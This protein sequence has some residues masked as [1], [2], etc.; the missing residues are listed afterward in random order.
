MSRALTTLLAVASTVL[1]AAH[2]ARWREEAL[3]VLLEVRGA[4]RWRYTMDTIVKVPVLAWHHRRRPSPGEPPRWVAAVSGAGL[5]G[6]P[7]LILGAFG[8]GSLISE[9]TAEF[10]LI[11]APAGMLP[12]VAA[13]SL[14]SAAS[15]GGGLL[16]YT[17]AV[18]LAVFAGT[19][20]VAA[21][22]L[23]VATEL[24]VIAIAGSVVPGAW[25]TTVCVTALLRR[26]GPEALA[27]IGAAAG[28][29][30]VGLLLGVQLLRFESM[31][32]TVLSVVS[33]LAFVPSFAAWSLWAGVRLVAG[34]S[35]LLTAS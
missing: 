27:W 3:A 21:G 30:L 7:V 2:R 35:E 32:A 4:R 23:S 26:A 10:L 13:R 14:R 25:L 22:L 9:D 19:G 6:M 8:L 5:L 1:P 12:V 29:S 20:P 24:P 17:A 28:M 11:V 34:R 31:I 16:R 15:R 18:V 33:L